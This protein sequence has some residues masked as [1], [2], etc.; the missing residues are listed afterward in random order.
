LAGLFLFCIQAKHSRSRGAVCVRVVRNDCAARNEGGAGR[1]GPGADKF[2]QSAQTSDWTHGPDPLASIRQNGASR[3]VPSVCRAF[4]KSAISPASRA[5]CL[6]P[7]PHDPRWTDTFRVRLTLSTAAG[8][9]G[10]PAMGIA[11]GHRHPGPQWRAA[12]APG[13]CSF[14]CLGAGVRVAPFRDHRPRSAPSRRL[15]KAP[16][17]DQGM[18]IIRPVFRAGITF[19]QMIAASPWTVSRRWRRVRNGTMS[20]RS[21]GFSTA[22]AP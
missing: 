9:D 13:P 1:R 8:P 15:R 3:K 7:A 21:Q 4:R 11:F 16:L 5:R 18:R 12:G 19:F 10:T 22:L 14:G 17:V 20:A 2:T 6:K